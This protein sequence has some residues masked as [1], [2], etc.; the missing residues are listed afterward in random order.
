[1]VIVTTEIVKL[2]KIFI[3]HVQRISE[4]IAEA[5]LLHGL[6]AAMRWWN[7]MHLIH[8]HQIIAET[9]NISS[10]NVSTKTCLRPV[11]EIK[12]QKIKIISYIE[13]VHAYSFPL[14]LITNS[15]IFLLV[16]S[17]SLFS[18][19]YR[20]VVGFDTVALFESDGYKKHL[21]YRGYR[22][23]RNGAGTSD[24]NHWLCVSY[25][26]NK[27]K[28]RATTRKFGEI[29]LVRFNSEH[30]HPPVIPTIHQWPDQ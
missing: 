18:V 24:K 1:M 7:W 13:I 26:R 29:E 9:N 22:Y 16:L 23:Y 14:F 17:L 20:F 19:L 4:R 25:Y 21:I 27:C 11:W 6:L 10:L 15:T 2:V 28:A 12:S 8:I 3:G 5:E 30:S